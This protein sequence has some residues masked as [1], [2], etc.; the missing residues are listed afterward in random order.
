MTR[1]SDSALLDYFQ[2]NRKVIN[3]GSKI[4][5][6]GITLQVLKIEEKAK[7]KITFFIYP[8]TFFYIL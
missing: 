1:P 8:L 5:V 6:Q 3:V 7:S 4:I 2:K